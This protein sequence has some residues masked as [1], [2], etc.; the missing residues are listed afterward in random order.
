MLDAAAH[1]RKLSLPSLV[2]RPSR[3]VERGSAVLSDISC[4]MGRGL[5]CKECHNYI[6][7]PGLKFSDLLRLLHSMVYKS[8]IRPQSFLGKLR[9]SCKVSFFYLQFGSKYDHFTSCTYN[10]AF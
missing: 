8:L 3:K 9:T 1:V 2:P 10:Y 6:L 7:H 5:W 4:H